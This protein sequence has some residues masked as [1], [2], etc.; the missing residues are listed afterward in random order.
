MYAN[1]IILLSGSLNELE[2]A[3]NLSLV[4][5]LRL[6]FIYLFIY[7]LTLVLNLTPV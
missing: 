4:N 3:N 1:N 5:E 6:I 7:L 2:N